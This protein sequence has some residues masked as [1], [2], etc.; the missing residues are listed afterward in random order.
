MVDPKNMLLLNA[1]QGV[2][3][4]EYRAWLS[5]QLQAARDLKEPKESCMIF[6]PK[7][8][9]KRLGKGF[10]KIND[11]LAEKHCWIRSYSSYLCDNPMD[12]SSI[13]TAILEMQ[14]IEEAYPYASVKTFHGFT[15]ELAVGQ[16]PEEDDSLPVCV[17]TLIDPSFL[18]AI[19]KSHPHATLQHWVVIWSNGQRNSV[20]PPFASRDEAFQFAANNLGAI[21]FNS[22]G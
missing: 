21:R 6:V 3:P 19:Q 1:T 10:Q 5:K 11:R 14:E 20:S 12:E 8:L 17:V 2:E 4:H 18:E 13:I 22:A 16:R 15:Q 7:S 9:A